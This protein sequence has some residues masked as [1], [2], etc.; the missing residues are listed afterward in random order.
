MVKQCQTF[1]ILGIIKVFF[2]FHKLKSIFFLNREK[3][4]NIIIITRCSS[5]RS[6]SKYCF[7]Q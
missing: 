4:K 7:N 6:E 2:K 5:Q 3:K 1:L